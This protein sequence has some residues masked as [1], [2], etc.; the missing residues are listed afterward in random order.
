MC[1]GNVFLPIEP[2]MSD[3][4]VPARLDPDDHVSAGSLRCEEALSHQRLLETCMTA[5]AKKG[6]DAPPAAGPQLWGRR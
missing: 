2:R 6:L 3:K 1:G 4:P 5:E